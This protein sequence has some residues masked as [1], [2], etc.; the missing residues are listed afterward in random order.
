VVVRECARAPPTRRRP[1]SPCGQS[2]TTPT[3]AARCTSPT[4]TV[5]AS[6]RRQ[7]PRPCSAQ[8]RAGRAQACTLGCQA[9]RQRQHRRRLGGAGPSV[10]VAATCITERPLLEQR[11]G[12]SAAAA[13][14]AFRRRALQLCARGRGLRAGRA[15]AHR[16]GGCGGRGGAQAGGQPRRRGVPPH[17]ARALRSR[18]LPGPAP[19]PPCWQGRECGGVC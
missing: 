4:T 10:G 9:L 6:G 8:Q 18:P 7:A 2:K 19:A 13:P 15:A 17:A 12:P 1:G 14:P 3:A 16:D 11:P 5:G